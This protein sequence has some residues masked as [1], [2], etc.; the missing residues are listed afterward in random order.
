MWSSKHHIDI[1]LVFYKPCRK[2]V[3]ARFMRIFGLIDRESSTLT[4]PN[5]A[6]Y[7]CGLW[8][9]RVTAASRIILREFTTCSSLKHTEPGLSFGNIQHHTSSRYEESL[10][11]ALM[12]S[13]FKEKL[14][15]SYV[16]S[17]SE[18]DEIKSY[19][20]SSLKVQLEITE[21]EIS[22]TQL[23][24]DKLNLQRTSLLESVQAHQCLISPTRR[25]P[26]DIIQEIFLQCLP[27]THNAVMSRKEA[28]IILGHICSAWREIAHNTPR[29]WSSIHISIPVHNNDPENSM[30]KFSIRRYDAVKEWLDKSGACPLSISVMT[31]FYH[32]DT[33][34]LPFEDL[35]I[36]LAKRWERLKITTDR[37]MMGKIAMSVLDDLHNLTHLDI[38]IFDPQPHNYGDV[39]VVYPQIDNLFR[40]PNLR[41]LTVRSGI[42]H[43]LQ[44]PVPW[45]QLTELNIE[46]YWS[47]GPAQMLNILRLTQNLIKFS[48][49][50]VDGEVVTD[51]HGPVSLPHLENFSI[52]ET[53]SIN[54]N[55]TMLLRKLNF[56]SLKHLEYVSCQAM[57][58]LDE[59]CVLELI[60]AEHIA[61][62]VETIQI[63]DKILTLEQFR[64]L[65]MGL[66]GSEDTLDGAF[67]SL[68]TPTIEQ[69]QCLCSSLEIFESVDSFT[70]GDIRDVMLARTVGGFS[71]ISPLRRV[72]ASFLHEDRGRIVEDLALLRE[73]G[74][75]IKLVYEKPDEGRYFYEQNPRNGLSNY[76]TWFEQVLE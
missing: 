15:T 61:N 52:Q 6:K 4:A 24:L 56:P 51:G 62:Y 70:E 23:I 32:T 38:A 41:G 54:L 26:S 74:M 5:K 43:I 12:E 28:P 48:C 42:H 35:L 72:R 17:V 1:A 9:A 58:T 49:T 22:R 25:L 37:A 60:S 76:P 10:L 73:R 33:G 63:R 27:T 16:P 67:I 44:L 46:Y 30:Y 8:S 50:L 18:I 66:L 3:L 14:G 57:N 55:L 29:L 45:V 47:L 34:I 64:S 68:I 36:P 40:A 19:I 53:P 31:P 20:S 59:F 69:P 21:A 75:D 11:F 13:P 39:E 71:G 65:L 7:C 2:G